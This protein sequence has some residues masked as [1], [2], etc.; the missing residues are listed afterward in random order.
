MWDRDLKFL[1]EIP[2]HKEFPVLAL[3]AN[4]QNQLY[5]SG[6]DGSLR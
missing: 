2:I 1:R 3:V 6:R 4:S 5:S